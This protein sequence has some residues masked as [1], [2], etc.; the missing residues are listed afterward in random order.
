VKVIAGVLLVFVSGALAYVAWYFYDVG[1]PGAPRHRE[2]TGADSPGISIATAPDVGAAVSVY[3]LDD[4]KNVDRDSDFDADKFE[5]SIAVQLSNATVGRSFVV[6][7]ELS[8]DARFAPGFETLVLH[9]GNG[10]TVVEPS[11]PVTPNII[12]WEAQRFL[13]KITIGPGGDGLVTVMLSGRTLANAVQAENARFSFES[14]VVYP[15]LSCAKHN[16]VDRAEKA[17]LEERFMS[18]ASCTSRT[19]VRVTMSTRFVEVPRFDFVQPAFTIPAS[20]QEGV[21]EWRMT[22]DEAIGGFRPTAS[23]VDVNLE[24]RGQR[25]L[26]LSG[27]AI[28]LGA[29]GLPVGIQLTYSALRSR[30]RDTTTPVPF[31]DFV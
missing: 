5:Q 28:G 14:P 24:A 7:V 8:G 27:V 6:A 29:A 4:N 17:A 11:A 3:Y 22:E 23:F 31:T 18:D 10:E 9:Q 1:L 19:D 15:I 12:G 21:V 20:G 2:R 30:R 26:F 13:F 16:G 25:Q